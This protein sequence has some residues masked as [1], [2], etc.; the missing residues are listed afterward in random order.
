MYIIISIVLGIFALF[1]IAF[2]VDY[3]SAKRIIK[4]RKDKYFSVGEF[5]RIIESSLINKEKK[6]ND[7]IRLLDPVSKMFLNSIGF[8]PDIYNT[9]KN[10][11]S[12]SK[13]INN[14]VWGDM[15]YKDQSEESMI[16]YIES[17]EFDIYND[18]ENFPQLIF[19]FVFDVPSYNEKNQLKSEHIN[20]IQELL[21]DELIRSKVISNKKYIKHLISLINKTENVLKKKSKDHSEISESILNHL[22]IKIKMYKIAL[23]S[24]EMHLNSEKRRMIQKSNS[25]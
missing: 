22:T 11:D 7:Y 23:Q 17:E 14:Y 20:K 18:W 1:I 21:K 19:P 2:I 9:Y 6:F 8:N 10:Y 3:I 5:L 4:K 25:N 16:N 24:A 12:V 15:A 13:Y